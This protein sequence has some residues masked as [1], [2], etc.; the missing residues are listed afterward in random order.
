MRKIF[1][2]LAI[3]FGILL[4]SSFDIQKSFAEEKI[5][6]LEEALEIQRNRTG[7]PITNDSF[8]VK[9]S[10]IQE[11]TLEDIQCM[12]KMGTYQ[13]AEK[14]MPPRWQV[15]CYN[16]TPDEINCNDDLQLIFKLTDNSPAC[17]NPETA[18]KL[19]ERGWARNLK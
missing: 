17:V 10:Y 12:E 11:L 3:I 4:I 8:P 18:E 19:I 6:T 9:N 13:R 5:Y 14:F 16:F 2:G 15:I 7:V 1:Y